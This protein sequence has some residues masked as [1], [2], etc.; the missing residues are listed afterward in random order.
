MIGSALHQAAM[1]ASGWTLFGLGV[2]GAPLPLHPGIPL[3]ALGGIMLAGRS[4]SFR[5]LVARARRRV[6]G[7]SQALTSRS[8]RWP[9][10]IRYLV[11]RTD[12]RRVLTAS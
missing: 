5:R 12:P 11:I 2:V 4:R 8:R 6:P 10:A 9:R 1:L 3:M 7:Y